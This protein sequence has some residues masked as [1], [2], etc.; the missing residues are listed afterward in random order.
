MDSSGERK[1]V[2]VLIGSPFEPELVGRIR[3]VD[4]RLDVVYRQDLLGKPRFPGDHNAP[5]ERTQAQEEEWD[6]LMAS[7]EVMLDAYRP[8]SSHLPRRAPRLR[9]IQFSSSGIGGLVEQMGL[10]DSSIL[11]TNVAGMH[12]TPLAEFALLSMLYFAKDLPS[13]LADQRQHRWRRFAAHSLNGRNLGIIGLGGVGREVARLA[14]AVGMRVA[15]TK[16]TT[17]GTSPDANYVDAIYPN[18]DLR[19]L[20][21]ESDYL[22]LSVPLTPETDG[23][24][25]EQ[26]LDAMKPGAILLNI[27]RGAVVDE[28]AMI[29]ALQ[30]GHLGGAALDVFA[31]EPLPDDSPLWDMPNVLVTSHSMSTVVGENEEVVDRFID[32]LHRYLAGQPLRNLFDRARGY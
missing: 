29:R 10:P 17:E 4:P 32:N 22:V 15:G 9:W 28:P 11:V 5:M 3:A 12:G 16:R 23:L 7:A 27:S 13:V 8:S 19:P 31:E 26:E 6:R 20:L 1:T 2:R 18:D 21:A 14:R 30:S 24:I 25:S